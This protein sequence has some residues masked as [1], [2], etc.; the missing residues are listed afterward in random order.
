MSDCT[1]T[2][3][4]SAFFLQN[5]VISTPAQVQ[6]LTTSVKPSNVPSKRLWTFTSQGTFIADQEVIPMI[7]DYSS[8]ERKC[9][10]FN[11]SF[12][13]P[14]NGTLVI[15][16]VSYPAKCKILF[17]HD[18]N[19]PAIIQLKILV[20]LTVL[21][22]YY[23]KNIGYYF[24]FNIFDTSYV[25]ITYNSDIPFNGSYSYTYN[26][27][28]PSI[29]D[30]INT[31]T[32]FNFTNEQPPDYFILEIA[33]TITGSSITIAYSS[34]SSNTNSYSVQAPTSSS[35]IGFY[36]F[37]FL[38]TFTNYY[39]T[40]YAD[41]KNDAV[42]PYGISYISNTGLISTLTINSYSSNTLSLTY[43][44]GTDTIFP[45]IMANIPSSFNLS[46][47]TTLSSGSSFS[48][49]LSDTYGNETLTQTITNTSTN[50]ST[51]TTTYTVYYSNETWTITQT[52]QTSS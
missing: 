49:Y 50:T 37:C 5:A 35:S 52:N 3:Q 21:R 39:W 33:N 22:E 4:N 11:F 7:L 31:Y 20:P 1:P 42:F 24:D 41:F 30:V 29:L 40:I 38:S 19:N 16:N 23:S 36:Y 44:N 47:Q 48:F 28:S 10:F 15:K 26:S 45:I 32:N 2:L 8:S 18:I 43:L 12:G 13:R 6:Y 14:L 51:N 46:I 25:D 34:S 27:S 17:E 9:P